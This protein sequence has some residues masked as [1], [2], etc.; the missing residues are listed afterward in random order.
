MPYSPEKVEEVMEVM[1]PSLKIAPP[2]ELMPPPLV[3][4]QSV[5]VE[6]VIVSVPSLK[7]APPMLLPL[8]AVQLVKVELKIVSVPWL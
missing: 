8:G 1:V 4:V 2:W 6:V 5:N 3:A 7:I